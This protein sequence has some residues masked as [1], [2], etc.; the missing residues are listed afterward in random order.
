VQAF[1]ILTREKMKNG[2]FEADDFSHEKLFAEKEHEWADLEEVEP[3]AIARIA[4]SLLPTLKE[5]WLS[6]LM[7]NEGT[8]IHCRK[9]GHHMTISLD[10]QGS[11]DN[12]KS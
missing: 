9:P 1:F 4:N 12:S 6:E 8:E 10:E 3:D 7:S 2:K 5:Q 11:S